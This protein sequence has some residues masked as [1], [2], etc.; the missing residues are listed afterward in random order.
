MR[1]MIGLALLTGAL[2][3][4]MLL[5]VLPRAQGEAGSDQYVSALE[6]RGFEVVEGDFLLW[7]IDDCP[8]SYA[9]LRT[10]YFNNP[11]APYNIAVLP[12]WEEEFVD[13]ATEGAFGLTEDGSGGV[14][15][16]DPNEAILV[17][18]ELPPE[19]AYFGLQSYLFTRQGEYS[20]DNDTYTY[21]EDLGATGIFFHEIPG[22]PDRIGSWDS[23]SNSNN[24]V[25]IERQ[26]GSS[27]GQRR[28][29]IITPDRYMDK[30]VR[31]VLHRLS[32]AGKDIFSEAIPSNMQVGLDAEA[33]EFLTGIRYSQPNDG[34]ADDTASW[35]WRQD[36]T[37]RVLRIRDARPNRPAQPYPAWDE[38]SP[39]LR[40]GVSES[41][42]QADLTALVNKVSEAWGQPCAGEEPDCL[43]S[44]Q[45]Q[46]FIDTQSEP[47]N[48]VG[49]K[50]DDIGMD[51][52]GDTQDASYQFRPGQT[53]DDDEVYAV[54]G[55]LG[56][57]TGNAT[58]V[59]LGVNNTRLRLGAL[60]VDDSEL[61]GSAE[62]Y[63]VNNSA[64]L[65]VHYFTRD[66]E[67]LEDLTHGDCTSVA[68]TEFVIP[69]G[70][71]ASFVERDYIAAGTQRGPDS[72]LTLPSI[73]LELHRPAG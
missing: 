69:S 13:Q 70:A 11:T 58:Y 38:D 64:E 34:G 47:F 27:W 2:A 33:D 63:G 21:L 71:R 48:L 44:G 65:Y 4:A 43:A 31:Q 61:A 12:A 5:P 7:G 67:G 39:E 41:Y 45:G 16:L 57:E 19:A 51:C 42:L 22:N 9:L 35:A 17:F 30:Q 29:F 46:K 73:A 62:P 56:T 15:R 55:T 23:L 8:D 59:S 18:G 32:V 6:K 24:N 50:C 53:F 66:C 28:Y 20:T 52:L 25:V 10:C 36:P 40:A 60:N 3:T 37:L 68:D 26:S 54:V 72:T 1:G 14:Y 49:P